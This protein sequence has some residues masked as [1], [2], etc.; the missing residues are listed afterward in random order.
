[1]SLNLQ[2]TAGYICSEVSDQRE[3]PDGVLLSSYYF[4]IPTLAL[5]PLL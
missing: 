2:N 4:S 3:T 1:M 5:T